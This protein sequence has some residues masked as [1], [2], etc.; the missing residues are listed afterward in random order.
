MLTPIACLGGMREGNRFKQEIIQFSIQTLWH[1]SQ[2]L[3]PIIGLWLCQSTSQF[4]L[5]H[6]ANQIISLP[7][8]NQ[9]HCHSHISLFTS[10]PHCLPYLNLHQSGRSW[11][12]WKALIKRYPMVYVSSNCAQPIKMR[13]HQSTSLPQI[14]FS[15][16]RLNQSF[17][18]LSP[19]NSLILFFISYPM[20]YISFQAS[21]NPMS[22]FMFYAFSCFAYNK[23]MTTAINMFLPP[24]E[25]SHQPLSNNMCPVQMR[26]AVQNAKRIQ[27]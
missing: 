21:D 10:P 18:F 16:Y 23:P 6:H 1:G 22:N 26:T 9:F 25:S 8:S 14:F 24:F 5:F 13:T 20:I 4:Y 2:I 11:A 15:L 17:N 7:Q 19:T 3:N 27:R 12:R